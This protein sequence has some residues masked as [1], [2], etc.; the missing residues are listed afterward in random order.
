MTTR[1]TQ[2]Q[3]I[4]QH[5]Y[6]VARQIEAARRLN[7]LADLIYAGDERGTPLR[8]AAN[9]MTTESRQ[10][11]RAETVFALN[12]IIDLILNDQPNQS[13]T[14]TPPIESQEK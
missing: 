8:R 11:V 10:H 14:P 9:L 5:D 1:K 3:R 4:A 6:L 12:M 13:P 7:L 2:S